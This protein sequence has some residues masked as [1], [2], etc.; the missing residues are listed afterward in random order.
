MELKELLRKFF[1]WLHRSLGGT[2][3]PNV[4]FTVK[5][6]NWDKDCTQEKALEIERYLEE[7]KGYEN[8]LGGLADWESKEI[9]VDLFSSPDPKVKEFLT[10]D[11]V[12]YVEGLLIDLLKTKGYEATISEERLGNLYGDSDWWF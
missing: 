6:H 10:L 8:R 11:E 12:R 9:F 1:I 5:I 7:V 3:R 4:Y 2:C